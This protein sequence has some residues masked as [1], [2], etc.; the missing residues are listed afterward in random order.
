MGSRGGG[1]STTVTTNLPEYARPYF[2]DLLVRTQAVTDRPYEAYQGQRLEGFTSD[3]LGAMDMARTARTP[4]QFAM[5]SDLTMS[6][7]QQAQQ[8]A[9][10]YAPMMYDPGF[11]ASQY[12]PMF[13]PGQYDPGFA[14]SQ[15]QST[16]NFDPALVQS[17][18]FGQ[19]QAG[20]YMSPYQQNVTNVAL[21]EAQRSA[22]VA[23]SQRGLE[24][25]RAGAFG[26]YRQA[27][28][29]AEADRNTAQQLSDIQYRG[30][31]DAF[32][33]AQQ[34]FERDRGAGLQAALANQRALAE[35]TM[36]QEQAQQFGAQF[37]ER[38]RLSAEQ[39][40]QFAAQFGEQS[41]LNAEQARQFGARFGEQSRLSEEQ[42]RQFAAQF[43]EGSLRQAAGLGLDASRVGI[44]AAGQ[45][46]QLGQM[47]QA[48]QQQIFENLLH[49]GGLQQTLG[50][51]A[52]DVGYE[53]FVNQRD[54][55]RGN[56]QF[57]SSVLRGTPISPTSE[58][59]QR[60]GGTNTAAQ[61][62]GGGLS[63]AALYNMFR[64]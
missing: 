14:A 29:Q 45:M 27:I 56:L 48:G 18:I 6:A 58:T 46:G 43:G 21:R 15:Y 10:M 54:Y 26:G 4:E 30:Q 7:A 42:A 34:Q 51:Q 1:T 19:E 11:A 17:G 13:T 2:E 61:L 59:V 63:A 64:Q 52:R 47:E 40:R 24:A 38:S 60:G 25:A 22:D 5:G 49:T 35:A 62:V 33:T 57:Y 41:L 53:N 31:Q 28:Q 50:Q 9:G 23:T 37:G 16:T 12:Q 3:Q 39:A 20:F 32:T 44:G 36:A 8:A 55:D